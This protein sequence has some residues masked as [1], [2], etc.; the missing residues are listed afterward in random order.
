M[1]SYY[2]EIAPDY[3][4]YRRIHPE[5]LRG[6]ITT[7]SIHGDSCVLEI[8]CGTGNYVGALREATGCRA[9]GID[10]S[11]Q[12]L[13][14]AGARAPSVTFTRENA[15]RLSF[16]GESFDLTFLVD[17]V[18]HLTDRRKA[19]SESARVL[20]TGGRLCI[21]TDSEDIIRQRQ[22]QSVY[23]PETIAVELSRYPA[24]DLLRSELLGEGLAEISQTVVEFSTV[25]TDLEPYRTQVFSSLRLISKEAFAHGM[26]RLEHD[27]HKGPIPWV[28]RYLMLWAS[29]PPAR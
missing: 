1:K 7:G 27:F 6:L 15:E 9:W 16:P 12:M 8:G 26:A 22:P 2:Q 5:V 14:Q 13:A 23:F 11:G 25:L 28:S 4:R 21:V 19:F 20:R 17:V 29:K 3:A 10:P 18:H 24:I